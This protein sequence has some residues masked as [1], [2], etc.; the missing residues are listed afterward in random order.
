MRRVPVPGVVLAL[1]FT[2][3]CSALAG[4][5]TIQ[6]PDYAKAKEK[7]TEYVD[8]AREKSG[9]ALDRSKEAAGVAKDK[10]SEAAAKVKQAIDT[11]VK[12]AREKLEERRKD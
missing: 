3:S 2:V 7:G 4:D 1:I 6:N 5:G 11:G 10:L 9:E 8:V 12:T